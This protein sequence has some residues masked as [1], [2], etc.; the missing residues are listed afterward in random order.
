MMSSADTSLPSSHKK[1]NNVNKSSNTKVNFTTSITK[2]KKKKSALVFHQLNS[3]V[4]LTISQK[5]QYT[6]CKTPPML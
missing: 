6:G 2:K 4:F 1:E 5:L 3:S